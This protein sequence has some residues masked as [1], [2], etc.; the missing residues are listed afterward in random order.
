[1]FHVPDN[2]KL[3]RINWNEKVQSTESLKSVNSKMRG[4]IIAGI[5]CDVSNSGQIIWNV[6]HDCGNARQIRSFAVPDRFSGIWHTRLSGTPA[7][8]PDQGANA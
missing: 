6:E 2:S 1:V 5:I 4:I 7:F 8:R 3:F